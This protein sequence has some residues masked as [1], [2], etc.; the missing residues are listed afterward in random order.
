MSK[1][2]AVVIGAGFG[3][4]S[5]AAH[6]AK[7][8]FRVT[9]LERNSWVG[10]RAQVLESEGYRF[11]MGPSWY[12][13]PGEHDR[14][15]S[16]LGFDRRD[17]YD[18]T[19]VDPSYRVYYG[20]TDP[21]ERENI[22]DIPADIESAAEVFESYET[23]AGAKLKRY[24]TDSKH[25]YDLALTHFIYRNYR[26]LFDF[27]NWTSIRNAGALDIH[28]SYAG[29][30]HGH[31]SHPYLRKILEFPV[32]FLGSSAATTPAVYTLM[33][34]VDFVLGT[35]YPDGGFARVATSMR[36][37]CESLGVE[38]RLE[39]EVIGLKTEGHEV[40]RVLF[41]NDCDEDEMEAD[42]VVA[43]ADYPHV[44][45]ELLPE[46]RRSFSRN[47]WNRKAL[48]PAVLNFYVG[49]DTSI[50]ELTHHTFFFDADWDTHFDSVYKNPRWIEEPLF[51]L[52]VPSKSDPN[53]APQGHEAV[54]IL[55]PIAPGL[56]DTPERRE[57]YFELV[58]DRM[59]ARTG[60]ALREHVVFRRSYSINDFRHD[61]NAYRGTAFGLGQTLLQTAY[62]RPA[63]RSKKL[64]N[65]YYCGHYTV[66]GTGTTMSTISG[67]MVAQRIFEEHGGAPTIVQGRAPAT[68]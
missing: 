32:V 35:W 14:W 46:Q 50:P 15:F 68:G 64:S 45:L 67:I 55:V 12:W 17:F 3:G 38:F 43:N 33:N 4:L 57:R 13:M 23:G 16:D 49:F 10:G 31:F 65:L 44:E 66:P 41:R 22:V 58:M 21:G 18:L 62:F 47:V 52:H 28:R 36:S 48:S 19:R 20:D 59:E 26:T 40:T 24:L 2:H 30:V 6:L 56:E 51:Y 25:K 54:Y 42:V 8:G 29:L 7:G 63:N 60:A 5:A 34:Y 1:Q 11:D 27:V 61:Y 39:T 9:L 53:V 37:V